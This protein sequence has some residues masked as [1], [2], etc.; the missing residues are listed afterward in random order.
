MCQDLEIEILSV[1]LFS[2]SAE[3]NLIAMLAD[4]CDKA[5][6]AV[7]DAMKETGKNFKFAAE[8]GKNFKFAAI[9]DVMKE[10]G[11]NFGAITDVMKEAGKN[12]GGVTKELKEILFIVKCAIV[13]GGINWAW[14]R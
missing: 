9:T 10:A 1:T 12:F 13:I 11:K 5:I 3:A 6:D 4:K 7:T 8:T 2:P 14:R